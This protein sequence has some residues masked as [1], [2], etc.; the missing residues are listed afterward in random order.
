MNLALWRFL[1]RSRG[2]SLPEFFLNGW[3]AAV[4]LG[5]RV[6]KGM[7]C[8]D[9]TPGILTFQQKHHRVG[10]NHRKLFLFFSSK[11]WKGEISCWELLGVFFFFSGKWSSKRMYEKAIAAVR[12]VRKSSYS[13]CWHPE[14][15]TWSPASS[16]WWQ[17]FGGY[18]GGKTWRTKTPQEV[19]LL[20]IPVTSKQAK[21]IHWWGN[22]QKRRVEKRAQE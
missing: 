12:L 7:E 15:W 19:V 11:G 5:N 17:L 22:H 8:Y 2:S 16:E 13:S 9:G 10:W 18:R 21:K 1:R 14:S 3:M 4:S 6:G 20:R